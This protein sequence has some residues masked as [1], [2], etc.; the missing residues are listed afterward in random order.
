MK[1]EFSKPSADARTRALNPLGFK[2]VEYHRESELPEPQRASIPS[3]V[4]S[5]SAP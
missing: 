3:A 2:V 5:G 1:V 4:S